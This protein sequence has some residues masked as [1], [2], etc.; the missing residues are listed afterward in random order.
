MSNFREGLS[1]LEYFISTH[2]ARKGLADT[3]LKTA[4]SGYLTRKLVDVAQDVVISEFDCGTSVGVE[5]KKLIDETGREQI[6][7]KE[8][9]LG[10]MAMTDIYDPLTGKLV[11]KANEQIDEQAVE[12]IDQTGIETVE[13]RSALTCQSKRGLC[14]LCYGRDLGRGHL[15]NIGEAGGIIAAQS[16]GEPG[17][18]LTM[19][20]FHIG[21]ALTHQESISGLVANEDGLIK[22]DRV[23]YVTKKND[24][25]VVMNRTGEIV[26]RE[27]D[28]HEHRYTLVLGALLYVK[29]GERVK[30]G[31]LM[32][33]WEPYYQPI[34]T[35]GSG[36]VEEEN[37]EEE[38][39]YTVRTEE[40]G[41]QSRVV[42]ESRDPN[43]R[44]QI[45]IT[46]KD[47]TIITTPEGLECRY[48]LPNGAIITVTKGQKV[49]A[50]DILAKIPRTIAK[51]RDITGG[52]P[53]VTELFEARR[54]KDPAVISEIDGKVEYGKDLKG[55]RRIVVRPEIGEPRDYLISK[56]KHILVK[57]LDEV[58]AGEPLVD[59]PQ[60]P[61]D[62]LKVRGE[63]QLAKYLLDEIQTVYRNQ[64]VRINDK[65]IEIIVRQ[66]LRRVKIKDPGDT[67]FL[68]DEQVEK[69]I[70]EEENDR[71]EELSGKPAI[72]EPLL[73]GITK[74]SLANESFIAASAFQE[75]TKIL[76]EAALKG[77][78]DDLRGLKENVIMG[79]LIPAGTG[80]PAYKR[81]KP[82]S[83]SEEE[84]VPEKIL[85]V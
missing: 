47:G 31:D 39:T 83:E 28:G 24:E 72:A 38:V 33:E 81:F 66:M 11:V 21:G 43:V 78:V 25:T 26:V 84:E 29:E 64:G 48:N 15:V 5:F 54:P 18:Q 75:T 14:V 85:A 62:I 16:I 71:V 57:P 69:Y 53:R 51:A 23:Q 63:I 74:A 49:D 76:T 30:K 36:V 6:P 22:F 77:R 68:V 41:R 52:L 55:K 40:T 67:K 4:N 37:I 61:Q 13:L 8:R 17:T 80:F 2:G 50:G 82:I 27:D 44:P 59:G 7:L 65:H 35:S 1:V 12:Q 70:F 73:L 58:K 20:T 46:E 9:I 79:R 32:A 19:R 10:R 34:L 60:N 42:I 3:A 45:T 56:G